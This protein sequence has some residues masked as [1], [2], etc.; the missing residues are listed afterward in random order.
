[1]FKGIFGSGSKSLIAY[2]Y[3]VVLKAVYITGKRG[4]DKD[5]IDNCMDIF[6]D[7][8]TVSARAMKRIKTSLA[9]VVANTSR[10][11]ESGSGSVETVTP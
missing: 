6:D 3:D 8:W 9:K 11:G 2:A 7:R 5:L 10:L 4:T 1:V